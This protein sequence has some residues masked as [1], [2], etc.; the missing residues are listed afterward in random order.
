[1]DRTSKRVTLESLRF[2]GGP[3]NGTSGHQRISDDGR[4]VVFSSTASN[5]VPLPGSSLRVQV[6]LRD[7]RTERTMLVSRTT[8]GGM[9]N[10]GNDEPDISEDGRFIALVSTATDLTQDPD[11]NGMSQDVYRYELE[12]EA[13][14]RISVDNRGEQFSSGASFAPGSAEMAGSCRSFRRPLWIAT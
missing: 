10:G 6:F 2:D 1:M 8:A 3:A 7:R 13:I 5:I 12:T 14:V 9:S 11:A 4:F